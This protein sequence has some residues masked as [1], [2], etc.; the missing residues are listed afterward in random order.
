MKG[1]PQMNSS[2][3][4]SRTRTREPLRMAFASSRVRPV[5]FFILL[6]TVAATG[7]A[8]TSA[9]GSLRR[10]VFGNSST[11]AAPA[12]TKGVGLRASAS[13]A[14]LQDAA[15]AAAA[16][17]SSAGAARSGH[18]ATLLDGGRVLVV[19]GDDAGT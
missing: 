15:N 7:F 6:V 2:K 9:A 4:P 3:N 19:G 18:T 14:Q 12:V 1:L 11:S 13:G 17:N 8:A 5:T 16:L 10:I